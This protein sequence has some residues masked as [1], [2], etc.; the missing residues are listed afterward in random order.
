MASLDGT[1]GNDCC[2]GRSKKKK[3]KIIKL[4]EEN[5]Y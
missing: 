3:K 2:N 1:L 4:N 5:I